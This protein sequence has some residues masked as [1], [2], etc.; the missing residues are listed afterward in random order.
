MQSSIKYLFEKDETVYFQV[1]VL[2]VNKI[3]RSMLFFSLE[4]YK[5]PKILQLS[6]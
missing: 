3:T 4:T 1:K 2:M 6:R 5:I